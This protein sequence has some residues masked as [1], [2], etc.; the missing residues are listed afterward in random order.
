[1]GWDFAAEILTAD[2]DEGILIGEARLEG[3]RLDLYL[4]EDPWVG[5]VKVDVENSE[6]YEV[7]EIGS[8]PS[9]VQNDDGTV[10]LAYRSDE[11]YPKLPETDEELTAY[12][13]KALSDGNYI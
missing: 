6:T 10:S 3:R 8:K 2:R 13:L 4:E 1:M 11:D 9:I 5:T 7:Q 12:V